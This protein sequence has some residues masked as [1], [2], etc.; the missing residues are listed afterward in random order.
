MKVLIIEDEIPA[1][2]LLARYINELIPDTKIMNMFGSVKE[3]VEWLKKN[4]HP[5]IIF[6]DVQLSDGL[7]F[8]I[9]E[10]I[11]PDSFI[12]FTTAYDQYAIQAFKANTIDYL[13]KPIKKEQIEAAIQKVNEQSKLYQKLHIQEFNIQELL[14]VIQQSK[15]HYRERFLVGAPDGWYKLNV[16][17]IAFFYLEYKNTIAVDSQ[18]TRHLLDLN[19]NQ[20]T[21]S[22]DPQQFYRINR[23]TIVNIQAIQKVE[24]WF[25]GKLLIK[26]K[27]RHKEKIIVA[28]EKATLF[29]AWLSK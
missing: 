23:Q 1:Q 5:D 14:D 19:L 12:I 20:I 10:Q 2:R 7:C 29:R 15:I 17:D 25:H 18:E 26:T 21:E 9:L 16:N 13:L 24:P 6:M 4:T 22:L 28:R 11:K 27:P 3:S 8:N